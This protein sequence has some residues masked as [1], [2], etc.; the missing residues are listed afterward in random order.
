[1]S[2]TLANLS[3]GREKEQGQRFVAVRP[4]CSCASLCLHGK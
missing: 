4:L 1:V 3:A 2:N